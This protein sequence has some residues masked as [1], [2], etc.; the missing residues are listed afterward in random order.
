MGRGV[1]R[2]G[3]EEVWGGGVGRG[4]GEEVWG[5]EGVDGYA[6]PWLGRAIA[7]GRPVAVGG[8]AWGEDAASV[9]EDG[10]APGFVH[11]EPV[12]GWT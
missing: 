3:G 4:C 1:G 2:G 8:P 6:H 9:A 11:G 12:K 10:D 5:G 7:L